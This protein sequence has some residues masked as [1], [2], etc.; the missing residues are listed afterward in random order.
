[1]CLVGALGMAA[2]ALF[3]PLM[4][5]PHGIPLEWLLMLV[6]AGLGLVLGKMRESYG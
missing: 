1:V 3:Q 4:Q 5:N 6:W 2:F